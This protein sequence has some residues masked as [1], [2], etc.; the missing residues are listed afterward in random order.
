MQ[1]NKVVITGIGIISSLGEGV[2]AHWNAFSKTGTEPRLE[3]E[4]FAPTLFTRWVKWIEPADS[5]AR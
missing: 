1:N 2:D 4:A 5:K 3:K